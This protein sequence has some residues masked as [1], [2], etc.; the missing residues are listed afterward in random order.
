MLKPG[1]PKVFK[2][3]VDNIEPGEPKEPVVD[4]EPGEVKGELGEEPKE[5]GEPREV[6]EP[7]ELGGLRPGLSQSRGAGGGEKTTSYRVG[8]LN[9]RN[10]IL[11][12]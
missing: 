5:P 12:S 2:E 7:G 9:I 6:M 8:K 10:L 11:K 1:E 3:P 4:M